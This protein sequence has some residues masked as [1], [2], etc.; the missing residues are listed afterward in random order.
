[1]LPEY[2]YNIVKL[3]GVGASTGINQNQPIFNEGLKMLAVSFGSITSTIIVGYIAARIGASFSQTIREKIYD[4][5]DSFSLE[6]LNHFST[7]SLITRSTNDVQQIQMVV[8]ISLRLILTAPIMAIKGVTKIIGISNQLSMVVALGI[9][10]IIIL[11]LVI[12][13]TVLPQFK[14]IQ[15]ITDNL[16]LVTRENLTGL[17][18]VRAYNAE[19]YQEH[20]FEEV[21]VELTNT[22]LTVNRAMA[23]LM[24]GMMLIMSGINLA[25]I[26]FGAWLISGNQLGT[27]QFDGLAIQTQFI[28]Y[29]TLIVMSFMM[30]TM[31]FIMIPRSSVSGK[32][33]NEV[34][35]TSS[36]IKDGNLKIDDRDTPL[37]GVIEFKN[38][39]FKYPGAEDYVLKDINFNVASGDTVAIIGS[40]GSGKSTLIN[41]ITR[42]YDLTEGEILVNGYNIKEYQ[43]EYLRD[44][45]GYVPQKGVLFSGT[46]RSNLEI[47]KNDATEDEMIDALKTAQAYEFVSELELGLDSPISQG[48][49]NVSG[50]QRQRLCIARAIIKDPEIYMF[51]DSFSALDYKT[52]K[53]LRSSLSERTQKATNIIVSLRI[54]TIIHADNIVV[55]NEGRVVGIGTHK[56]LLKTCSVYQEIA[57]SQLSKEE[58]L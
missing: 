52:D 11:I 10:I 20:K 12:F 15:K 14:K 4:K 32:R 56:E 47:G 34:L 13:I 25:V 50:G 23:I 39:S 16:N 38:V 30:L 24:P 41:L 58:L 54:G 42:F 17:R 48:G 7:P 26:W 33:I 31:L 37:K 36:K 53:A 49:K 51:D 28:I 5:V 55:L 6:E 1:M 27:S 3:I 57:Y 40:T 22:N 19:E 29:S 8:T 46:I 18:V 9:F 43:Q 21:N 45:I 35:K 44:L 2:M